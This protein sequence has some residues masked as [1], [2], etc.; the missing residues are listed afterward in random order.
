MSKLPGVCAV[1]IVSLF[2][3][4]SCRDLFTSSIGEPFSRD[5]PPISSSASLGTLV[6]IAQN[7]EWSSDPGT[8]ATVL[9]ILA[10]KDEATLLALSI[11]D[12]AAIL[13]LAA[14]AAIDTGTIA[15]LA[16]G[17]EESTAVIN[18]LVEQALQTFDPSI[19]LA[20][21]ESLLGNPA[22][23]DAAPAESLLL[24]AA[25]LIG[26][27]AHDVG[28]D[29]V[30]DIMAG[31]STAS[32]SPEQLIKINLARDVYAELDGRPAEEGSVTFGDFDLLDLLRGNQ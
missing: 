30:M 32:L 3:G 8:A 4:T 19:N 9:D 11:E 13:N 26:D 10:G 5:S 31:G 28:A 16:S 27:V 29:M 21:I 7:G 22:T 23:L 17:A 15:T 14:S 12:Q 20:A 18:D 2:F 1:A 24:S 25:V 6:D